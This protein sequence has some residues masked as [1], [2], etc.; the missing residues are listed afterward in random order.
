MEPNC[1][2]CRQQ[3]MGADLEKR[4]RV[5]GL[6]CS[7]AN[8]D[9]CKRYEYEPGTDCDELEVIVCAGCVGRGD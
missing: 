9:D 6:L 2:S 3:Y 4:C 8:A 7:P 5:N 1:N